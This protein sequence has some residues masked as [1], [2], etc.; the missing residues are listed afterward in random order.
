MSSNASGV[1]LHSRQPLDPNRDFLL[2]PLEL[3]DAAGD[4]VLQR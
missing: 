3:L 1:L 4:V 2:Q